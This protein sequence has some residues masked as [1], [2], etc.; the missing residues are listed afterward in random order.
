MNCQC[1]ISVSP[2][3]L[4]KEMSVAEIATPVRIGP[5]HNGMAMTPEEFDAIEEW[6]ENYRYELVRGVLVVS[7]PAGVGETKP[8]DEL[9]YLLLRYRDMHPQGSALDDTTY[10]FTIR[11]STGRRRADR[12][13]WAGL[14]RQP[15]YRSDIPAVAIEWVARRKRDRQRDHIEKRDEYHEAGVR[16]YWVIDRFRRIMTV[17]RGRD[18]E[19][20]VREGETYTTP[21]LPGFELDLARL[22]AIADR[23]A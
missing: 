7:P 19:I 14:G 18:Q 12:V 8:N 1:E 21:L 17:Y 13:I 22:L 23:C 10:E 6:D 3:L 5:E 4:V 16:E 9:G 11:T 15:V 2:L 20:V